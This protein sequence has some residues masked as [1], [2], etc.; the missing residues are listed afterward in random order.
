MVG[1]T[2][3]NTATLS[4]WNG[5]T[6]R[7]NGALPS[8]SYDLVG[9]TGKVSRISTDLRSHL[10][11][12]AAFMGFSVESWQPVHRQALSERGVSRWSEASKSGEVWYRRH[13]FHDQIGAGCAARTAAR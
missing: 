4:I 10:H 7:Q 5:M 11:D 6:R 3:K 9:T 12:I 2:A 13:Q 8:L 1:W